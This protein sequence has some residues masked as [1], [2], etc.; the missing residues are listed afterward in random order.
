MDLN[1]N[2]QVNLKEFLFCIIKWVGIDSD[3]EMEQWKRLL[4]LWKFQK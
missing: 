2:G 1:K 4:I 3:D